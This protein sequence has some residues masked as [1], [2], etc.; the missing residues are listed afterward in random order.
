LAAGLNDIEELIGKDYSTIGCVRV[1]NIR[2]RAKPSA[3]SRTR[4]ALMTLEDLLKKNSKLKNLHAGKRCFIIGN[5]PSAKMQNLHLLRDEI[6]IAVNSFYCHPDAKTV[7]PDYWILAD[8]TY[9]EK[10]DYRLADLKLAIA[11]DVGP[12]LFIP[13][14]GFGYFGSFNFGPLI[15]MHFYHYDGSK[16]IRS[17]ID[18]AEGVP[19][20]GQNVMAVALMLAFYLGC[21]PIYFIGCDHDVTVIKQEDYDK[22]ITEHSFEEGTHDKISDWL[23]W[24]Q[25]K[26]SMA[27]MTYEYEQLREYAAR[28]GFQVFN[29]THGGYFDV[30]PRV[31]YESLFARSAEGAEKKPGRV[32]DPDP[33]ELGKQ[34]VKLLNEGASGIALPVIEAALRNNIN[35]ESQVRGL[36][37]LMALCLAKQGV[38]DRALLFAREDAMRNPDNKTKSGLLIEQLTRH[39]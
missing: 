4:E 27:R 34:A 25:Y 37:Y 33:A 3:T 38:Y 5:G 19:P 24:E 11:K 6:A 30:F 20:Y 28:W 17:L 35:R 2:L 8:P 31:Q 9:W 14:G 18:F 23:T 16:D 15:D 22:Y 12:K 10:P 21:S 1:T 39:V 7:D 13:S 32:T 26:H 36:E 29:A